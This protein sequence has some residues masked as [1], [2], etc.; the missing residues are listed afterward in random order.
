MVGWL[1]TGILVYAGFAAMMYSFQRSFLYFPSAVSP[2][3]MDYGATDMAVVR[4]GAAD[5]IPAGDE[6]RGWYRPATSGRP[7]L[8]YFHGNA[9]HIG[10]RAAKIRAY[11][12]AG[13]GVLLAAYRGYGGHSGRPTEAGLYADARAAIDWLQA[14]GLE[15]SD[16]VLYGESLGTGVAVQ[17][18][19]EYDVAAIVLEAPFSS[20]VDVGQARFPFLPVGRLMHDRFDSA[21]KIARIDAPVLILHGEHDRTVP[22]RFGR[23]L[24]AASVEP[25]RFELFPEAGHNDLYQ[26]GAAE[27]VLAFL[28]ELPA[29]APCRPIDNSPQESVRNPDLVH[30]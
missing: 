20:V 19:T 21:T 22:I 10:D 23:R 2:D 8:V 5:R 1:L 6:L 24:Y 13:Y 14:Q 25:R 11:L 12:D 29:P 16:L 26:H 4:Y 17:I 28:A 15:P 27:R 3:R 9:G 18:G 7:T 30:H